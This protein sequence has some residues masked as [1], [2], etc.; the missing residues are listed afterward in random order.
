ML[1]NGQILVFKKLKV[2]CLQ[3]N[4]ERCSERRER[5]TRNNRVR[6]VSGTIQTGASQ[7]LC[8]LS[9][10]Y[11]GRNSQMYNGRIHITMTIRKVEVQHKNKLLLI[12]YLENS[13]CHIVAFTKILYLSEHRMYEVKSLQMSR[14]NVRIF[15]LRFEAIYIQYLMVGR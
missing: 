6:K 15:F 13:S 4:T 11:F 10:Y 3:H 12:V 9:Y 5:I 14:K 8:E 2:R 7:K 1:H